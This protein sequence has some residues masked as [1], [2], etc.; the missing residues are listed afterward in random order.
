MMIPQQTKS[1]AIIDIDIFNELKQLFI[2]DDPEEFEEIIEDFLNNTHTVLAQIKQAIIT[3]DRP[4]IRILAHTLKST[5]ASFGALSLTELC[6]AIEAK[7][8]SDAF[9]ALSFKVE[10]M[11]QQYQ[12][13]CLVI[14]E[15]N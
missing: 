7:S 9:S 2:D 11:Q 14:H 4:T 5:L 3:Q 1:V 15:I 12:Q 6:T 8:N 10:K 13:L